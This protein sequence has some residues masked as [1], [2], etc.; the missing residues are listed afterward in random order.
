MSGLRPGTLDGEEN[1][2]RI[3]VILDWRQEFPFI[4]QVWPDP[5][6]MNTSFTTLADFF[7]SYLRTRRQTGRQADSWT[8]LFCQTPIWTAVLSPSSAEVGKINDDERCINTLFLTVYPSENNSKSRHVG[9]KFRTTFGVRVVPRQSVVNGRSVEALVVW[10]QVRV[11]FVAGLCEDR[12]CFFCL[13][14]ND[15]LSRRRSLI[16]YVIWR[17]C[18]SQRGQHL[19]LPF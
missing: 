12:S 13:T 11:C 17:P 15:N 6:Q 8:P 14:L 10:G 1:T 16:E 9:F 5:D 7:L 4:L 18:L 2:E 3:W 19:L